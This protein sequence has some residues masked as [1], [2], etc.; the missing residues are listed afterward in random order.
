MRINT[1]R[2]ECSRRAAPSRRRVRREQGEHGGC[3]GEEGGGGFN[4]GE[5]VAGEGGAGV[6][7]SGWPVEE[8]LAKL[9]V[10]SPDVLGEDLVVQAERVGRCA[11]AGVVRNPN[12]GREAFPRTRTGERLAQ[13][14][15]C[16]VGVIEGAAVPVPV[17]TVAGKVLRTV[18]VRTTAKRGYDAKLI[19]AKLRRRDHA[20]APITSDEQSEIRI[21]S[22]GRRMRSARAETLDTACAGRAEARG[23]G[24]AADTGQVRG[25]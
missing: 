23:H 20:D 8:L 19:S 14:R 12:E 5:A 13:P 2:M 21:V 22:K 7:R 11:Q 4:E 6:G 16:L 9:A 25:S 17:R 24:G 3:C 18:K 1:P 10:E 15:R